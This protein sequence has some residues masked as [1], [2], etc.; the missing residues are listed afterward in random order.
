MISLLGAL[1]SITWLPHNKKDSVSKSS[2]E[3]NVNKALTKDEK[4]ELAEYKKEI[5]KH[6]RG[7]GYNTRLYGI[8]ASDDFGGEGGTVEPLSI[9]IEYCVCQRGTQLQK[10]IRLKQLE[11]QLIV[12]RL[13]FKSTHRKR[14]ESISK[15]EF[16]AM[17]KGYWNDLMGYLNETR[18]TL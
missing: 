6:C 15:K 2:T 17:F 18:K 14:K 8:T 10:V 5:C 3:S 16:L 1:H 12:T 9:H 13:F 4:T 11:S 7:K